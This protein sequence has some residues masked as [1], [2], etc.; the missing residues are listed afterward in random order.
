MPELRKTAS[1]GLLY[2]SIGGLLGF[3]LPVVSALFGYPLIGIVMALLIGLFMYFSI[4]S[5]SINTVSF[6]VKR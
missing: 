2:G 6:Y 4:V 5:K 3:C 1:I